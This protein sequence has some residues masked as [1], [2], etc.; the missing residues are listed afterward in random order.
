MI[1]GLVKDLS[2]STHLKRLV[3]RFIRSLLNPNWECEDMPSSQILN[4][5]YE[6]FAVFDIINGIA[7]VGQLDLYVM[8]RIRSKSL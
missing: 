7:K 6:L 3:L 4:I 5:D 8:K 2:Y 1:R